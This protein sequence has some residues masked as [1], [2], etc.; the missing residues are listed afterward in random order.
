MLTGTTL[1]LNNIYRIFQEGCL[2]CDGAYHNS[3]GLNQTKA[4]CKYSTDKII[5]SCRI[6][7]GA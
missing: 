5:P 1:V 2:F 3:F 4:V 6:I 7:V